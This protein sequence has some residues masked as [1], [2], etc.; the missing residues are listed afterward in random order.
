MENGEKI[1]TLQEENTY[2]AHP[3]KFSPEDKFSR[4]RIIIK[5]RFNI[6]PFHDL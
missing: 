2:N 6:P 5:K 1:Y 3:A 4:E